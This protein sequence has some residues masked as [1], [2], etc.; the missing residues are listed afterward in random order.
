MSFPPGGVCK[1]KSRIAMLAY[2]MPSMVACL[3]EQRSAGVP[4]LVEMQRLTPRPALRSGWFQGAP[5]PR[6][7]H[8]FRSALGHHQA[9]AI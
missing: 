3:A 2:K 5:A 4:G 6:S 7:A 1:I 8:V 9:M